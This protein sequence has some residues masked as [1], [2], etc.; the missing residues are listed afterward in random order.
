MS[1]ESNSSQSAKSALLH[2]LRIDRQETQGRNRGPATFMVAMA[3]VLALLAGIWWLFPL[4]NSFTVETATAQ[5]LSAAPG[6]TAVLDATGYVTARRQATVSSKITGRVA[7]VLIEEGQYVKEG[8]VLARLDA[9]DARAQW[10]LAR[11]QLD[12]ARAQLADLRLLMDQAERDAARQQDLVKQKLVSQQAAD[13]ANTLLA[14]RRSRLGA[15][16]QEVKVAERNVE[17]AQ[18]GL[19]NTVIRAPFAGVI[20]DKAAQPGE[21]VS[22]ISAGGGFTR[23]GIGTI[24]DMDSLE[25]E[26]EVNESYIGRVQAGQPVESSLNAY[27]EWKIPGQVIAIIPAADRSKA[28]VKVRISI[29]HQRDSRVVPDMGVRVAFLENASVSIGNQPVPG[30]LI[31]ASAIRVQGDINVVLVVA[32]GRARARQVTLGQTYSDLRQVL[33][34]LQAN[35]RVV[36]KPPAELKDGD[37]VQ[38][39]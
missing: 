14:S 31:P 30:V 16:E 21:I 35:E 9:T 17:L 23:T 34:G 22:P 15:Q 33:T 4:D 1:D 18:V 20:T 26:V 3:V 38:W 27:P 24:V 2:Q 37:R 6:T 7:E 36:V 29:E 13:D 8:E 32:E 19:D 12:V 11:A 5:S 25:I 28:T 10:D 39:Q